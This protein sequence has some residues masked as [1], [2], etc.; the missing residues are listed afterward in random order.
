MDLGVLV[1]VLPST[2]EEV[3]EDALGKGHQ[4][5]VLTLSSVLNLHYDKPLYPATGTYLIPDRDKG[6]LPPSICV[7][8]A[9]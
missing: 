4:H 2:N 9:G 8:Y 7:P 1:P 3:I 6:N 5:L